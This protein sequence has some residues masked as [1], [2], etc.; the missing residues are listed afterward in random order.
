MKRPFGVAAALALGFVTLGSSISEARPKKVLRFEGEWRVNPSGEC[1]K[2][3]STLAIVSSLADVSLV[4]FS[5]F[6]T[7][8]PCTVPGKLV[9]GTGKVTIEGNLARLRVAGT[10]VTFDGRPIEIDINLRKTGNL[11]DP[12]PGVQ[13]VSARTTGEILLD[14]E[15]LTQGKRNTSGQITRSRKAPGTTIASR[16]ATPPRV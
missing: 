2:P 8:D 1:E 5:Y 16:G 4:S 13:A 14:G 6:S 7:S 9:T 10:I 12:Q 11:P 3:H 15:D